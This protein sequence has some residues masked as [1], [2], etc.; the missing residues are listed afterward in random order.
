[1]LDWDALEAQGHSQST[2]LEQLS[3]VAGTYDSA[4]LAAAQTMA[5]LSGAKS[6]VKPMELRDLV[7][8][9]V[10][11]QDLVRKNGVVILP[12]GFE[13]DRGLLDHI[14]AFAHELGNEPIKVSMRLP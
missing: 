4:M 6:S 1:M 9:M 14:H 8:G 13:I 3:S 5:A 11:A 7:P 2:A 12:R 10:L